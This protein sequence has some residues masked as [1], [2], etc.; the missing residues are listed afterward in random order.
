MLQRDPIKSLNRTGARMLYL[1][2][3]LIT[4]PISNRALLFIETII[5]NPI[6]RL[7]EILQPVTS[8]L[9][10]ARKHNAAP[11]ARPSDS[12]FLD[13]SYVDFSRVIE[14][15]SRS[16]LHTTI[17]S[18]ISRGPGN[19]EYKPRRPTTSKN[20]LEDD[21][22]NCYYNILPGLSQISQVMRELNLYSSAQARGGFSPSGAIADKKTAA[23][24]HVRDNPRERQAISRISSL[25]RFT[26]AGT[27]DENQDGPALQTKLV[28]L[29]S[30]K[31]DDTKFRN[32]HTA[33]MSTIAPNS[34][35][36]K[37]RNSTTNEA[38][39]TNSEQSLIHNTSSLSNIANAVSPPA[40]VTGVSMVQDASRL[41]AVLRTNLIKP[42]DSPISP[43]VYDTQSTS[44]PMPLQT[45]DNA[46]AATYSKNNE[47]P[48]ELGNSAINAKLVSA[49]DMQDFMDKLAEELELEFIRTYGT[50][51][52]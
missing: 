22:L 43:P 5:E 51:G 4:L 29:Q 42:A 34:V 49:L 19:L 17:P 35:L 6:T 3:A 16:R 13:K 47:R 40:K 32:Q 26:H 20:H 48:T 27:C 1:W 52:P 39:T 37:L 25:R 46:N 36:P 7:S 44:S 33:V 31:N 23:C 10:L 30:A 18:A 24:N 21:S 8:H 45:N 11:S 9:W 50:S 28:H 15:P 14:R 2:Q 41:A 12:C 38:E